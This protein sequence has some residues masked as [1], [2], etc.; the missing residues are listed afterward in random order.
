MV[1]SEVGGT[2][3]EA[4]GP[5]PARDGRRSSAPRCWRLRPPP[6][7]PPPPW[8]ASTRVTPAGHVATDVGCAASREAG[9][10]EGFFSR[11][12]GP[13]L[14][15]D[16]QHVY[17][18]GANRWLWLF[19]DAFIDHAGQA[20]RLDG[21]WLRPQRRAGPDRDLLHAAPSRVGQPAVVL[22]AR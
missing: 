15:W 20:T 17:P 4:P 22:R 1:G 5:G 16:Y 6:P 12:V 7:P 9:A 2:A 14:G 3:M 11:R 10:L 8:A 18:L 21:V 19:Q 13:V